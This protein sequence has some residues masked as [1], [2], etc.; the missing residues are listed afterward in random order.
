MFA[1]KDLIGQLPL[2]WATSHPPLFH[3]YCWVLTDTTSTQVNS[4]QTFVDEA[5]SHTNSKLCGLRGQKITQKLFCIGTPCEATGCSHPE[6]WWSQHWYIIIQGGSQ[7]RVHSLTA[8]TLLLWT[9]SPRAILPF[10]LRFCQQGRET[11]HLGQDYEPSHRERHVL[12]N[13]DSWITTSVA[14]FLCIA[15]L[16]S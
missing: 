12:C 14:A 13:R 9:P 15:E 1:L 2:V 3:F 7:S 11:Q 5:N 8:S 6:S 4:S 16:Q 10:V